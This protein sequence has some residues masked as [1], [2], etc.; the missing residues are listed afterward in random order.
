MFYLIRPID[1]KRWQDIRDGASRHPGCVGDA[2]RKS[3]S[4]L[5]GNGRNLYWDGRQ[6]S[7]QK[8]KQYKSPNAAMAALKR[9]CAEDFPGV[10]TVEISPEQTTITY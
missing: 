1:E 6:W 4:T 3:L 7:T 10:K 2:Y 9:A 8:P 5:V